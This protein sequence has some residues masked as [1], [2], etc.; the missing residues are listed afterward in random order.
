MPIELSEE[1]TRRIHQ[2]LHDY[3]LEEFGED[4]GVLRTGKL[5]DFVMGLIGASVYNQAIADA[6]AWLQGKMMDLPGDLHQQV[7]YEAGEAEHSAD[8]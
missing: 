2:A 1:A 7:E 6:Q 8:S 4:L 5:L 3:V